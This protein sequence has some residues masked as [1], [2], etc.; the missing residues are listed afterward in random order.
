MTKTQLGIVA[1]VIALGIGWTQEAYRR[2]AAEAEI[3]RLDSIATAAVGRADQLYRIAEVAAQQANAYRAAY[4]DSLVLWADRATVA[5]QRALVAG[6]AAEIAMERLSVSLDSTETAILAEVAREH[7]Q[8][9]LAVREVGRAEGRA[10]AEA[11]LQ[12]Q[13]TS[14]EEAL[15]ASREETAEVRAALDARAQAVEAIEAQLGRE[16]AIGWGTKAI[17]A[18]GWACVALC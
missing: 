15:A 8:Q 11:T 9:L 18:A 10:Q 7:E 6:R 2:G 5:Q 1:L 16:R 4:E 3:E 12:P 17:A 13:I 14:L